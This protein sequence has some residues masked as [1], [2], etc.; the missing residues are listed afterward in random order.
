MTYLIAGGGGFIGGHLIRRLLNDGHRV[1][2][3][4]IK[5]HAEWFQLHGDAINLELIDLRNIDCMPNISF[6]VDTVI[7]LACDHGG[8]GYLVN[9]EFRSLFDITIN[10]N[11]LNFT[12][13]R[14]IKNYLFASTACVYNSTLQQDSSQDVYLKESDAWPALPDMKYGLEK[15]YGEEMCMQMASQFDIN[16]YLPRIHGCYGPYNHFNNIKEKAPN[17]ILRKALTAHD[18]LE[19]WGTGQQRRS[20]MYIDDAVEGICRLLQSSWHKPIN[21][22]SNKTVTMDQVAQTAIAL[23]GRPLSISHIDATVGV[24]SRSSDNTLIQQV[25]SWQPNITIEQGLS[26]T[27]H[28]MENEIRNHTS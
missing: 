8:I 4:D 15:L 25:L 22:G 6:D 23:V 27:K 14:G 24:N 18:T 17:A 13:A 16:V 19:V 11:L 21:L 3:V 9:N 12:I 1:V 7:N 10:I 28:W 2:A 26:L 20:F 5:P